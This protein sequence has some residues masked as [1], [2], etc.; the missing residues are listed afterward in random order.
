MGQVDGL[1][2]D[3]LAAAQTNLMALEGIET[4]VL[5]QAA[6]LINRAAKVYVLGVGIANALAQNFAYLERHGP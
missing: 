1:H 5:K 6:T 3:V 4:S 2:H